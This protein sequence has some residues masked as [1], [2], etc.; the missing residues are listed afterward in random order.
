VFILVSFQH[1]APGINF[2]RV[3]MYWQLSEF[4]YVSLKENKKGLASDQTTLRKVTKL[5]ACIDF[6]VVS[7]S[8]SSAIL[9]YGQRTWTTGNMLQGLG[10]LQVLTFCT[11]FFREGIV[12]LLKVI[13]S[14]L[15][16]CL[17]IKGYFLE[18]PIWWR[19]WSTEDLALGLHDLSLR[20]IC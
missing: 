6:W 3:M 14:T 8:S 11:G 10:C 12:Q 5:G 7:E 9:G 1:S 19:N 13:I 2:R 4:V 20:L 18:I 15:I 17:K 16:L